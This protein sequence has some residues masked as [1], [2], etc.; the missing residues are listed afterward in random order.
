MKNFVIIGASAAG[1][2]AAARIRML[3]KE[4]NIICITQ[5]EEFPYNKC[6]LAEY[7]ADLKDLSGLNIRPDTFFKDNNIQL[8][9]NTK[10]TQIDKEAQNVIA[11]DGVQFNYDKL[12][13]ATG[14]S[15][16][17]LPIKGI[18]SEGV[19]E[20]YTLQN[21]QH[22]LKYAQK[23]TVQNVTIIGAGLSGLECADALLGYIKKSTVI[24]LQ[25]HVLFRLLSEEVAGF[26]QQKMQEHG[27]SFI[28]ET[29]V[30]EIV[31]KNGKVDSVILSDG[32]T[33]KSD[34]VVCALGAQPNSKLAKDAGL[35]IE[36]NLVVTN[37]FLQTSDP[38]IFAAGDVIQTFDTQTKAKLKS[39]TWPDAL[40]QG[41]Y[42]AVNM[43]GTK[44]EYG[45][46]TIIA[47]SEFFGMKFYCTGNYKEISLSYN[48]KLHKDKNYYRSIIFKN[49]VVKGFLLLGDIE[50]LSHFKRSL[51]SGQQCDVLLD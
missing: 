3:D 22:I 43:T 39:C 5:E 40:V 32:Q 20:F 49:A 26:I 35:K 28:P 41:G 31:Q 47:N 44:K 2:A 17:P 15:I 8:I 11:Q 13:Y 29:T 34:M 18:D 46:T 24:E 25:E 12:L 51:L 48:K 4:S 27:I 45:G 9:F 23:E 14:G 19:F 6:F 33:I 38:H 42:A 30:R 50:H 1:I 21:T 7:L 37:K 16:K 10:I 36:N